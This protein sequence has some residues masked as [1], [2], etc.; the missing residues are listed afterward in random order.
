MKKIFTLISILL[1]SVTGIWAQATPNA[2]FETWTVQGSFPT[3]DACTSWDSPNSQTAITGIFV[4]IKTTDAHSGSLAMKLVSKSVLGQ[5]APGVTTTGILP[6]Q[7]GGVITG[8]VAYTLRPDSIVGWYKFTP[9]AAGDNGFVGFRLYGSGGENDSVAVANYNTASATVGT[10]T[11]FSQA[12]TYYS[13]NA[14]VNSRW[15]L[16]STKD[17][18]NAI[19]NST[20]FADDLDLIFKV[21][22]TI[23]LTSGTNPMCAGQS[24]TFTAY[25]HNGGTTPVYQWKVDGVNVGTNSP[26]YTTTT[27]TTGQVVTCVLTSN[28]TGVTVVG[29]PATSPGIT[30]VVNAAPTTPVISPNGAV[31]TSSAASGNQWYLNGVIISGA[32]SQTYTTTQSG[33]YTVIVTTNGCVSATSAAVVIS[34]T[35]TAGVTIATTTGTNPSCTGSSVTFTATPA[36]GGTT[37]VYQWQVDGVNVGTNSPTYTTTTLTN[38]EIVTCILTSNYPSVVGSPATSN[39]I[40]MTV[41][42]IPATPVITANGALLTSSASAGN[43]WYLNSTIIPNATNQTYTATQNGNYTVVVT[44]SGCSSTASAAVNVINAGIDQSTNNYFFSVYPNPNEGNFNVSFNVALKATYKLELRNTLGQLV[45][46]ET[47]TDFSGSY[48]KQM[49]VSQFGKGIYLI[50]L[51]NSNNNTIKKIVVY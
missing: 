41:N 20:L 11:R 17:G 24:A 4:C 12:L 7:N 51:T 33:S 28:L 15:L 13:T 38:G 30:M 39:V 46:N 43:Q 40:T 19:V 22:D 49:D 6:T 29:S 2:G 48:S 44:V 36:N 31:L 21:S 8:G 37:P 27:L 45:Y 10:Y 5:I 26:T 18:E 50:S 25:P 3:Y 47:L 35:F 16:V 1:V 34:S 32:T 9:G 14:V 23:A 42:A